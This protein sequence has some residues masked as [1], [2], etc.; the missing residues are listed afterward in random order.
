MDV[1]GFKAENTP[2]MYKLINY[3]ILTF[4][5]LKLHSLF[6]KVC[7]YLYTDIP[8]FG[9]TTMARGLKNAAADIKPVKVDLINFWHAKLSPTSLSLAH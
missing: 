1:A 4:N 5:F 2:E 3:L 9:S 6:F 7:H 8:I